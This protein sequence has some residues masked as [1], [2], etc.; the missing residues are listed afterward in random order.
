MSIL[1]WKARVTS[2]VR[3]LKL[4]TPFQDTKAFFHQ[5]SNFSFIEPHENNFFIVDCEKLFLIE[6]HEIH[7]KIEWGLF[8]HD[9]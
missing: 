9:L 8:L 7:L 5:T 3:K 1:M 2:N 4:L 6:Y